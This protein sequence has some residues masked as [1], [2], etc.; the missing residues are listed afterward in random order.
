MHWANSIVISW[1]I[2]VAALI[3]LVEGTFLL[4]KTLM[5]MEKNFRRPLASIAIAF[6]MYIILSIFIGILITKKIEYENPIWILPPAIGLL[7]AI[8]FVR[9]GK[10]LLEEIERS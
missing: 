2:E 4:I 7:S 5:K 6:S 3:I 9:G 1:V 8:M 10:K